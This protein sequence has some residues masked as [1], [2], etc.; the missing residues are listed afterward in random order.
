MMTTGRGN[1][2]DIGDDAGMKSTTERK[3]KRKQINEREEKKTH[4][5]SF[6]SPKWQ[7]FRNL[8]RF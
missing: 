6:D 7:E 4:R 5:F 8:T 3:K 1:D 2:G